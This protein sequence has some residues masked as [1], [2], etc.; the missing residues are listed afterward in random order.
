MH[1]CFLIQ[2]LLILSVQNG[3]SLKHPAFCGLSLML[4][5]E[6]SG[7]KAQVTSQRPLQPLVL[8]TLACFSR[9][10]KV[11]LL[12]DD[13]R[14]YHRCSRQPVLSPHKEPVKWV[15]WRGEPGL[16]HEGEDHLSPPPSPD[17]TCDVFKGVHLFASSQK[18]IKREGGGRERLA[19]AHIEEI[20]LGMAVHVTCLACKQP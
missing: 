11:L 7:E 3:L 19:G 6:N 12:P 2:L 13:S 15:G 5:L 8:S 14:F 4:A 17:K 9:K 16:L 10:G 1:S 20:V 18:I